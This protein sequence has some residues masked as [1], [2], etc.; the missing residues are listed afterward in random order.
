[1]PVSRASFCTTEMPGAAGQRCDMQ[2]FLAALPISGWGVTQQA[3]VACTPWG[4]VRKSVL[5]PQL[6]T[7]TS[8][9][10]LMSGLFAEN[11]SSAG[12][13]FSIPS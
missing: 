3:A 4:T 12:V 10:L 11:T 7:E 9:S 13:Y 5:S 6:G 2:H 8:Q 1:M